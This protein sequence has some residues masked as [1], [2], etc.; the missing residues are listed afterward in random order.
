SCPIWAHI[1]CHRQ[2]AHF[3]P[4]QLIVNGRVLIEWSVYCGS[5]IVGSKQQSKITLLPQDNIKFPSQTNSWIIEQLQQLAVLFVTCW[6]TQQVT[7]SL[8]LSKTNLLIS[9]GYV[10]YSQQCACAMHLA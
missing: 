10:L 9:A 8:L 4:D 2:G 1:V 6:L 3:D 7:E 5:V